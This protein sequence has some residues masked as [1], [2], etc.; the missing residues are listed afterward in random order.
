MP[1]RENSD[2]VLPS[3][4]DDKLSGFDRFVSASS[5]FVSRGCFFVACVLIVV[6]WAPT[7]FFVDID[8]WQLMINTPTTIITFLLVALLQNTQKR[9]D[10]AI[11][12]KLNTVTDGL[13]DLMDQL[14]AEN[15]DL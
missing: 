14:A 10:D 4:V 8:T 3:H 13:S 1:S 12:H 9:A 7:F 5:Q 2:S 6:I 15:P 11:Q